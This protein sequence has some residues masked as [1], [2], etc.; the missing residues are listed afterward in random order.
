MISK[1][2]MTTEETGCDK[3]EFG[4]YNALFH[5][6]PTILYTVS[7][8][9]TK[10]CVILLLAPKSRIVLISISF[11]LLALALVT[12]TTSVLTYAQ[13]T[14]TTTKLVHAGEGNASSV[15]VAFV[16]Q[17][18][19]IKAG[20]SVTWNNPTSVA[21]PHS[22][23]FLKDKKYFADYAAAFH[24]SNSTE[25][26]PLDPKSNTEP[27]F[28]PA[29]PG[30]TSKTVVTVNARAYI[31]VVIDSS[32]NKVRYLQP[33]SNYTM[34]GTESYLNSGWLWPKGMSPPGIPPINNFT[35]TFEKPGT[36]SYLCNVHPWMT[37]T[38]TVK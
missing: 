36:Y 32:G 33:N 25:F 7:L 24:I 2:P 11:S 13:P 16:P 37:G 23:T 22:V 34:N 19:E 18:M 15:I 1:F 26:K 12:V 14:G 21:E 8:N 10:G 28:A 27:L 35:V 6:F 9:I 5:I 3:P 4:S 38:V 17:N 31:P 30:E 29:Q 20:Q